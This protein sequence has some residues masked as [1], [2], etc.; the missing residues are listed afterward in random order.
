VTVSP[1][2]TP[3]PPPQHPSCD[4]VPLPHDEPHDERSGVIRLALAAL[5]SWPRTL[6]FLTITGVLLAV[7]TSVVVTTVWLLPIDVAVG[8]IEIG[9]RER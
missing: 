9:R 2:P 7:V 1:D 4:E 6:R 8:P 3:L 5:V